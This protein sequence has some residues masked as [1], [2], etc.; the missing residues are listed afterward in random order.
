M[1]ALAHTVPRLATPLPMPG[2]QGDMRAAAI[3]RRISEATKFP[4]SR[5]FFAILQGI[6]EGFAGSDAGGWIQSSDGMYVRVMFRSRA[7]AEFPVSGAELPTFP[8]PIAGR[9]CP[10]AE[11]G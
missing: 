1:E 3:F 9:K 10:T 4:A 6:L 7:L 11:L 5:E 2:L 8:G